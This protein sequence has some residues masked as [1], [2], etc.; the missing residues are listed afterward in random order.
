M[1]QTTLTPPS[2]E[3]PTRYPWFAVRIKA[4]YEKATAAALDGKG[5]EVY[6]PLYRR[7]S[8][9]SDR[10][11]VTERPLFPGYLF[12]RFDYKKRLPVIVT[13]GVLSIV[14]FG[15]E[16]A[17]IEQKQIEAVQAILS[18]GVATEPCQFLQEGQRIR[19]E[20][21]PLQGI[22]GILLKKKSEWRLVISIYMLQRSISIEI[23]RGW[24]TTT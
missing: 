23:D 3:C 6:L 4:N 11:V 15:N 17:P 20:Y 14:E 16:P 2:V 1:T 9:W 21:G 12:C 13:P 5:Y 22:E 19:I 7:R 24:I 8:R 18:S 10:M